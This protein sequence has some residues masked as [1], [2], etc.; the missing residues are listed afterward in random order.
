[1]SKIIYIIFFIFLFF[2]KP[3]LSEIQ[4]IDLTNRD[5]EDKIDEADTEVQELNSSLS[6]EK[7]IFNQEEVIDDTEFNNESILNE[8]NSETLEINYN[9]DSIDNLKNIWINS[10]KKNVNF[11]FKKLDSKIAS[12]II[13]NNIIDLI[14]Y[15][16]EPPN[17]MTKAEFDKLR[18][19]TLRKLG[20]IDAAISLI[21][22]ISTYEENKN[23]YDLIFL[24][25]S[26]IEYDLVTVCNILE[27]SPNFEFDSYIIKI[28]IF[29][30]YLNNDLEKA[31]FYNTLLLEENENDEYFQ[32]LYNILIEFENEINEISNYQYDEK[33][34]IL[35]SAI[36][37]SINLPFTKDFININ[38]P[39]LLKTIAISPSTKISVRIEAAQK[40]FDL[41]ELSSES[42][43]AIYQSVDFTSDELQNPLKTIEKNYTNDPSKA[44]ALLFQSSRI[45]ILPISRLEALNNL[46]EYSININESKLAFELSKDLLKTI[47]PSVELIDFALQ[48]SIVHFYNQ[49]IENSKEW[50]RLFENNSSEKIEKNYFQLIFLMNLQEDNYD[51]TNNNIESI[52]E[53]FETTQNN[54]RFLELYLTTLDYIGFIIPNNL[55]ELT[56]IKEKDERTIPSIYVMK[57]IQNASEKKLLGDLL[58][59]IAISMEDNEWH[60]IHPQHVGLI[61]DNLLNIEEEKIVKKIALEILKTTI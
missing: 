26:L 17:D 49:N 50:L 4:I 39:Q 32:A 34:I 54:L 55:W 6:N 19:L 31:E 61:F 16:T 11:L 60:E 21:N 59:N 24:E 14:I 15:G 56:A 1:M 37:R 58:L 2:I 10:S 20:N 47:E 12:K 57:L 5:N 52:F 53:N 8:N 13:K 28:N 51:F 27:S 41:N 46:W 38:S 29:C 30:S 9:N 35:Y 36:M 42:V 7:E 45:Q 43:A 33:S 3:V 44:M 48:T 23:I 18:I 25:K 22:N 40:A